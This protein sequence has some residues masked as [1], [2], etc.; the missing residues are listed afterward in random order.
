[1]EP[2]DPAF[3]AAVVRI[4]SR[5]FPTGF[6]VSEH[7]PH[8]FEDLKRLLNAGDRLVVYSGGS[9]STIYADPNVNYAFRAW[10]DW[11]HWSGNHGLSFQGEIAVCERQQAH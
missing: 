10:H 7:G 6:D 3:N 1:M 4:A 9:S 8:T 2:L 11:S 5:F